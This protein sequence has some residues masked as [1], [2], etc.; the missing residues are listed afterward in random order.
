MSIGGHKV[1][2]VN[3]VNDA[4]PFHCYRCNTSKT[5]EKTIFQWKTRK[6]GI[7]IICLSC[8]EELT[9]IAR[10]NWIHSRKAQSPQKTMEK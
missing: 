4:I 1:V 9:R 8:H 10:R 5:D 3:Y 6:H 7:K 2:V